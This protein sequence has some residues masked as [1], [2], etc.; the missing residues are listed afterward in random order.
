MPVTRRTFNRLLLTALGVAALPAV[1]RAL[2]LGR[3]YELIRP[4]QPADTPDTIEVLEFF[5]YGCPHC[6]EFNPQVKAWAANLP[7]GISFR[8]VPVSFGRSAWAS[9]ARLY[10]ALE[11]TGHLD[12]LDDRVF[13][14]IHAE[15]RNLYTE[16]AIH[17][18]VE[19]QGIGAES[20]AEAFD[21]FTVHTFLARS[22]Q[23]TRAH[24]VRSV[25]L[26]TVGGR[27]RVIGLDARDF[28]G[29]FAIADAL[30]AQM[31]NG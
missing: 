22:D 6:M 4:A 30:I 1:G 31:A 8:R 16:K 3:D 26:L 17:A 11:I 2:T 23:L 12:R 24:Q 19:E 27:Y 10:Y 15:R 20:F 29:L 7:D 18:W 9:L 25:P 5:S 28:P 14:A 13:E 21:S